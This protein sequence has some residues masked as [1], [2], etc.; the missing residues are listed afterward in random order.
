MY[1]CTFEIPVGKVH[2]IKTFAQYI[3]NNYNAETTYYSKRNVLEIKV[4]SIYYNHIIN[5]ALAYGY[6]LLDT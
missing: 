4:E 5:T 6:L 3:K 2:T 1:I